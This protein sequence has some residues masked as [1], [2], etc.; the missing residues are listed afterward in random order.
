MTV[1]PASKIKQ[2]AVA[3]FQARLPSPSVRP[4]T[5]PIQLRLSRIFVIDNQR[6]D[7]NEKCSGVE[8]HP[9]EYKF[10]L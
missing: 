10:V 7:L 8:G 1:A 2:I 9:K 4:H 3:T 5:K 6:D